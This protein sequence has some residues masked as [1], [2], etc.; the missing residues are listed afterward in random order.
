MLRQTF[1]L[2][3]L[4][5]GVLLACKGAEPDAK[6][7]EVVKF[8]DS[9]WTVVKADSVGNALQGF[10]EIKTT[11]GRFVKIEYTVVNRTKQSESI[12]DHPKLF[13]DKDREFMPLDSQQMYMSDSERS[14]TLETMSPDMPQRF[15][16]IYDLPADSK[17]LRFEARALGAFG[18]RRKVALGI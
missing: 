2:I 5:L 15:F 13:D 18:K 17:G 14:I 6:I 1:A 10:T 8:D 12:L 16:A 9:E 4:L 7:G 3:L 11:H